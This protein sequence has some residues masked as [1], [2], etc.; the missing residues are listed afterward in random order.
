MSIRRSRLSIGSVE[1]L[2]GILEISKPQLYYISRNIDGLYRPIKLKKPNGAYREITIPN[3]NLKSIQKK[4]LKRILETIPLNPWSHAYRKKHSPITYAQPHV[5]AKFLATLDIE[6][7]FPSVS[8]RMVQRVFEKLGYPPDVSKALTRLATYKG[9]LPQGAPT[10]PYIANLVLDKTDR[11]LKGM[12]EQRSLAYGR[13]SDDIGISGNR[14]FF[15]SIG[16]FV[17]VIE[18]HGF[19]E[20][21][22]KRELRGPSRR[23]F[24]AGLIVNDKLSVPKE[25]IKELRAIIHNCKRHGPSSQNRDNKPNFKKHLYGRV[26]YI[27]S[28]NQIA[29]DKLLTVLN[30]VDWD[31]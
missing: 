19:R 10:S 11:V 20:S 5:G 29:G 26:S 27:R 16:N 13:L 1:H 30:E 31:G 28:V 3:G 22:E 6:D 17:R 25:Q 18:A 14:N 7:F 12:C 2:C 24:M 23:K 15:G 4:I 21:R 8:Y 9:C